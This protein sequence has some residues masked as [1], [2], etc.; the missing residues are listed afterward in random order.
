LWEDARAILRPLN[1][2][3]DARGLDAEADAWADRV[4]VA[5]EAMTGMPPGLDTPAGALWLHAAGSRANREVQRHHFDRAEGVYLRIMG[6]L[7]AMDESPLQQDH[8]T[9][10][11]HQL[12]VVA[13]HRA[14][15][16]TAHDWYLKAL[17]IYKELGDRPGTASICH[18]LG[19]VALE[20]GDLGAAQDW[21]QR[22][23]AIK[24]ELGDRPE[25][26]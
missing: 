17:A 24:E 7:Q 25:T 2:Y 26:R 12:G 6:A 8:L 11:Y 1:R 23:L 4:T 14:D 3:W 5:A 19:R 9:V 21:H 10:A 15:L 20:R 18:L 16:G 13:Q 22:E